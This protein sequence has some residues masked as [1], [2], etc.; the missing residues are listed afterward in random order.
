MRNSISGTYNCRRG[1]LEA[2]RLAYKMAILDISEDKEN[3]K[4]TFADRLSASK[5]AIKTFFSKTV[6]I[7]VVAE[8]RLSLNTLNTCHS[9]IKKKVLTRKVTPH[10][11]PEDFNWS[12]GSAK[13]LSRHI[14][15]RHWTVPGIQESTHSALSIKD[16]E[17]KRNI[18][19]TSYGNGIAEEKDWSLSKNIMKRKLSP[20]SNMI[21]LFFGRMNIATKRSSSYS[22]DKKSRVSENTSSKLNSS[23]DAREDL[24]R[25]IKT[26]EA[27]KWAK[28]IPYSFQKLSRKSNEY[29]ARAEKVYIPSIGHNK[30]T[31]TETEKSQFCMFGL[32]AKAMEEKWQNRSRDASRYFK[33]VSTSNNCSGTTLQSLTDGGAQMYARYSPVVVAKPE[34]LHRFSLQLMNRIGNS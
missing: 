2:S 34:E 6:H 14:V 11:I 9:L 10:Q 13:Q 18:Y 19:V 7:P 16:K 22:E 33:L 27:K 20:I 32:D 30:N 26:K 5:L 28:I 29:Q 8:S 31:E 25:G 24:K 4:I 1:S 23:D 15:V 3:G 12:I 17:K 21:R